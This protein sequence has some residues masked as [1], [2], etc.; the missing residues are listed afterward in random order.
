[1][2][3]GKDDYIIEATTDGEFYAYLRNN[4][5]CFA[6]GESADEACENLADIA[7][8]YISDVYNGTYMVEEFV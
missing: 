4:S 7:E 6:Y 8:D 1:M 2:E 5:V 3:L